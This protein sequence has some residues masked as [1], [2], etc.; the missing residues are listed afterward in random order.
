MYGCLLSYF[1]QTSAPVYVD[2]CTVFSQI[3]MSSLIWASQNGH[4]EVVN[5]LLQ[6]G[7]KV[8]LRN[9]VISTT[10]ADQCMRTLC[11]RQKLICN[12]IP[13]S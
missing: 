2:V 11:T 6:H 13:A 8:D 5:K 1:L 9:Q 3:G 4:V 7:A 10:Y 12:L